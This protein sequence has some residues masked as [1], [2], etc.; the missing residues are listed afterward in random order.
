MAIPKVIWW[1]FGFDMKLKLTLKGLFS[2]AS[3][4]YGISNSCPWK[5]DFQTIFNNTVKLWQ[6][7]HAQL[8]IS[9]PCRFG[10]P[11]HW[12][13]NFPLSHFSSESRMITHRHL[14]CTYYKNN[15]WLID[16]QQ[17]NKCSCL[18]F[19]IMMTSSYYD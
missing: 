10:A 19:I 4:M 7:S 12:S 16:N 17:F 14:G 1:S 11:P 6:N 3:S 15:W 13:S 2:E 9:H 5:D 8:K 18:L